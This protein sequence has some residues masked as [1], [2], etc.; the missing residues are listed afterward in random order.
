MRRSRAGADSHR[1][2]QDERGAP[3]GPIYLLYALSGTAGLIYEVAWAR[4][5][6]LYLG[7]LVPALTALLSA[8]LGGM[9]FGAW[10]A[11]RQVHQLG[12]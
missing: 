11:G 7:G 10:F 1:P 5:F 3:T 6:T 9:A 8:Y 2:P 4:S 12:G